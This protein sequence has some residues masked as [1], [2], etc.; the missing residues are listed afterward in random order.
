MRRRRGRHLAWGLVASLAGGALAPPALAGEAVLEEE[1]PPSDA[2][3]VQTPLERGIE[4]GKGSDK[5]PLFPGVR[6]A[7]K[8]LPPVLRDFVLD[9]QLRSYY[10]DRLRFDR[11]QQEAFVYGG[12]V[13]ARTGWLAEA[14]QLETKLMTSQRIFGLQS[15]DGTLLLRPGQKNINVVGVANAKLRYAGQTFT[16]W[17]QEIDLP[18]VNKQ[19]NRELPN[20]FD[21]YLVRSEIGDVRAIGGQIFRIKKRDSDVFR[22]MSEVAGVPDSHRSMSVL[23]ARWVPDESFSIGAIT[24]FL[25]DLYNVAYSEAS[26]ATTLPLGL[27]L[28]LD[29][30]FTDL[31]SVGSDLLGI[32]GA[33]QRGAG[34]ASLSYRDAVLQLG[35]SVVARGREITNPFGTDPSYLSMMQRDFERSDED[36]F[37]A[38]LSYDLKRHGI[39]LSAIFNYVTATDARTNAGVPLPDQQEYDLTVDW[40]LREGRWKGFWLRFR[41]SF[42]D[43][44]GNPNTQRDMRVI[45]N[46]DFSVL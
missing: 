32:D 38:S 6:D 12:W 44:A 36:A 22:P 29:G 24:E 35:F 39:P 11:D 14:L 42:L 40:K 21:A 13:T 18:F 4:P 45:L 15:R 19:D 25:F 5:P 43:E 46:Y 7:M 37:L 1:P 17:R 33:G 10:Y 16:A 3:E 30:Q 27:E 26:W 28:K 34:R 9:V 31:R 23:G 20:T 8:D 2:Y 41:I